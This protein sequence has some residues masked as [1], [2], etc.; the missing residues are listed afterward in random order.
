[1]VFFLFP[2]S[3]VIWCRYRNF[4]CLNIQFTNS[5]CIIQDRTLT[6]TIGVGNLLDGL[7]QL[8]MDVPSRV[9]VIRRDDL[10]LWHKRPGHPSL[11]VME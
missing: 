7:Y 1:M 5:R 2:G 9:N 3:R 11:Q 8:P 10:D 4:Y 6:T